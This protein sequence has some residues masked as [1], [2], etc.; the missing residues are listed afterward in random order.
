MH[1]DK[2]AEVALAGIGGA[3]SDAAERTDRKIPFGQ[4][5][6]APIFKTV[7]DGSKVHVA[8]GATCGCHSNVW[9]RDGKSNKK[10]ATCKKWVTI[11]EDGSEAARM[12]CKVWLMR[13]LE[14]DKTD[15][16][17]RHKHVWDHD[18]EN[19]DPWE[20]G[21]EQEIGEAAAESHLR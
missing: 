18:C 21:S 3:G 19:M 17:G 11:G 16:I 5:S 9:E 2:E 13:G 8:W 7:E 1:E 15:D 10:R 6:I 4:W 20:F 12:R 14:I